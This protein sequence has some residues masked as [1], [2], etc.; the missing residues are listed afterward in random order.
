MPIQATM[1]PLFRVLVA[2]AFLGAAYFSGWLTHSNAVFVT[3]MA[4]GL[5]VRILLRLT[6]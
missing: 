6:R 3:V 2:F 5:G 1:P 4:V